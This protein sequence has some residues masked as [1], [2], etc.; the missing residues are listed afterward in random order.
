MQSRVCLLLVSSQGCWGTVSVFTLTRTSWLGKQDTG[1]GGGVVLR[2]AWNKYSWVGFFK[3]LS[4]MNMSKDCFTIYNSYGRASSRREG[5]IMAVKSILN[6]CC[7]GEV[8]HCCGRHWGSWDI[9]ALWA[10]RY[11][12]PNVVRGAADWHSLTRKKGVMDGERFERPWMSAWLSLREDRWRW[13]GEAEMCE[14]CLS[15]VCL[16]H[17]CNFLYRTDLYTSGYFCTNKGYMWGLWGRS[18]DLEAQTFKWYEQNT[19]ILLF[20]VV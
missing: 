8:R 19:Y 6:I 2:F 17:Y 9:E 3:A 14:R 4:L 18:I 10:W 5:L 1:R 20:S 15:D 7:A 11:L 12:L 13:E 16:R